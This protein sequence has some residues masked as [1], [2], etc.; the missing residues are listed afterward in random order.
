MKLINSA[1]FTAVIDA[2]V[3]FPVVIRDYLIWLS[4]HDLYTPKWSNKLLD[5]FTSIFQKK[6]MDLQPEQISR[7]VKLINN[8]CPNALVAKY[9]GLIPSI[10]LPDENDRHV[11]AAAIK[12]NA[13]VIVTNNLKDFPSEYLDS[14]GLSVVDPDTFIADMIDLS[15]EKCCDAF[16]EMVLAKNKPPY[17]EREYLEVLRRNKLTQTAEE[18]EKYLE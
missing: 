15:P 11:V 12:C 14:F 5:E 13:N 4:I 7:Q 17:T 6:K 9:E 3:L 18:L 2:N 16:R 1:H 8:A 10:D